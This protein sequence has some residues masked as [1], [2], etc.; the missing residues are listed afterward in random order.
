M[1]AYT[2]AKQVIPNVFKCVMEIDIKQQ[3]LRRLDV[4]P[5]A[6]AVELIRDRRNLRASAEKMLR[7][8]TDK[9]A[10]Q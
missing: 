4:I 2:N 10:T 9:G 1:P 3:E 8:N 6:P 5:F 7:W